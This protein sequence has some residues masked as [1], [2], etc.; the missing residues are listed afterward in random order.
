[1]KKV[2]MDNS[3]YLLL[4]LDDMLVARRN[5]VE[6]MKIKTILR[7]EFEMKELETVRRKITRD[8]NHKRIILTQSSYVK[9]LL[10]KFEMGTSKLISTPFA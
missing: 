7:L 6:L 3:I 9:K 10:L 1:M 8:R 5:K 4:Y 2:E